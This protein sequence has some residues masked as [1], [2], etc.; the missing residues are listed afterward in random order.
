MQ[1]DGWFFV[2][3]WVATDWVSLKVDKGHPE[4]EED[5]EEG[6][7]KFSPYGLFVLIKYICGDPPAS[8]IFIS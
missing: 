3:E 2:W 7:R 5:R 4:G 1:L 6:G 8:S